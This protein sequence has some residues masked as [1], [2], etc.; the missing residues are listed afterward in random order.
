MG[1]LGKMVFSLHREGGNEGIPYEIQKSLGY[2]KSANFV[3]SPKLV[4]TGG[5]TKSKIQIS[6]PRI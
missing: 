3:K 5:E 4:L 2:R 1:L 6:F